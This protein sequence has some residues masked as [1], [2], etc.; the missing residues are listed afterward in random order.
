MPPKITMAGT[1]RRP[2]GPSSQ[3]EHHPPASSDPRAKR[4]RIQKPPIPALPTT[5]PE[6]GTPPPV[7]NFHSLTLGPP[8][9]APIS[10]ASDSRSAASDP[11][12]SPDIPT[13]P[14]PST[15][16]SPTP[17]RPT[18]NR[19][20]PPDDCIEGHRAFLYEWSTGGDKGLTHGW[21][22]CRKSFFATPESLYVAMKRE[23]RDEDWRGGGRSK[24][25]GD[26]EEA[27]KRE[28]KTTN[29][30]LVLRGL[31][32]DFVTLVVDVSP[33]FRV[34]R[35]FV[36]CLAA[37][38]PFRPARLLEERCWM[39]MEHRQRQRRVNDVDA[40]QKGYRTRGYI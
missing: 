26:G 25:E 17:D 9:P 20:S 27:G 39:R 15:P 3:P 12:S 10:P 13:L 2:L 1:Q 36:D 6:T 31:H 14:R 37:R 7:R 21:K 32:R 11:F 5:T 8:A 4:T 30:L 28:E 33:E 29:R 16:S 22:G 19:K 38:R 23:F 40:S 24:S 34:E 18:P 35:E